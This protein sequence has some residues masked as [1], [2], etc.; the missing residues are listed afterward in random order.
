M[1]IR[2]KSHEVIGGTMNKNKKLDKIEDLGMVMQGIAFL[3]FIPYVLTD[4]LWVLIPILFL[5]IVGFVL[6][7]YVEIKK[8]VVIKQDRNYSQD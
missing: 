1:G 7:T 2:I 3:L 4:S 6:L 5:A 8:E